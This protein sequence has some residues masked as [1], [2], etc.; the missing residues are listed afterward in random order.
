MA[1]VSNCGLDPNKTQ[2]FV[3]STA[4]GPLTAATTSANSFQNSCSTVQVMPKTW[5]PFL[6][7]R[8][9]SAVS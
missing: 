1:L 8:I 9:N 4:F 3:D 2:A 5:P 6:V 7:H